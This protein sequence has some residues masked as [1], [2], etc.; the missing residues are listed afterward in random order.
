MT[1]GLTAFEKRLR[2]RII[3]REQEFFTVAAPGLEAVC[4]EE[5]CRLGVAAGDLHP[6]VGGIGFCGK[7]PLL[8]AANLHLRTAGRI[9]M[10]I[11]DLTAATFARLE[12]AADAVDWDLYLKPG[13]PVLIHVTTRQCRLYHTGAVA[14]RLQMAIGRRLGTT[15]DA[16]AGDEIPQRL[17]VKGAS[18]RFTISLDSSGAL[19]HKRGPKRQV[20]AAPIRETLAAA[21]LIMAGHTPDSPV[22]DPMCG[23]GTFSLEAAMMAARIPPGWY[24]D[25]AF[26]GWPCFSAAA[27]GHI[28]KTAME[29]IDVKPGPVRI[30]ASD[31]RADAVA[32]LGKVA[33]QMGVG[34]RMA[35]AVQDFYA[36]DGARVTG[37]PGTVVLNPPYGLRLG[38][39][40]DVR[41]DFPRIRDHLRRG[42]SG[43][44]A[45]VFCPVD[46]ASAFKGLGL[47]ETHVPHGGLRLV[48]FTGRL[49]G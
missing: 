37:G 5:L 14:G 15:V 13:Q 22:V 35:L 2:R 10:R 9:L 27:W 47:R 28:R 41:Q 40:N 34:G 23:S 4:A 18:D 7:L 32:A 25:F 46:E 24:R 26:F 21:A 39:R 36:V 49:P 8:Y 31:I 43:W 48:L 45:A 11:A 33:A 1:T 12:T 17:F 42:F 16:T 19:L 29:R 44:R 3:G 6:E 20:G 38:R 30:F